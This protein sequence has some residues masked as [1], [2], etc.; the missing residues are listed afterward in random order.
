MLSKSIDKIFVVTLGDKGLVCA[1]G[2][3]DIALEALKI[4]VTDT[5]GAGDTFCGYFSSCIDQGKKLEDALILA[6]KAAAI[7]CTKVGAQNSVPMLR[8]II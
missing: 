4:K 6:N 5:V 7:A 1:S 2:D 3:T 8:D